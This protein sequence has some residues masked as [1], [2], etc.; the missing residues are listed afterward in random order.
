MSILQESIIAESMMSTQFQQFTKTTCATQPSSIF[1]AKSGSEGLSK[2]SISVLAE[3]LTTLS[4]QKGR[5]DPTFQTVTNFWFQPTTLILSLHTPTLHLCLLSGL[6][7][8]PLHPLVFLTIVPYWKGPGRGLDDFQVGPCSTNQNLGAD[9]PFFF[10][11]G[12]FLTSHSRI[13]SFGN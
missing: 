9:K 11:P 2:I 6:A 10:L 12:F 8:T 1:Y 7:E 3:T 5:K 13:A 4:F